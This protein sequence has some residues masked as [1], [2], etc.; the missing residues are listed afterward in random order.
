ASHLGMPLDYVLLGGL[1]CIFNR[2]NGFYF[3]CLYGFIASH[4]S[5]K[6]SRLVLICGPIVSVACGIWCGFL[7]DMVIEPF[8]LLLGKKGYV[9]KPSTATVAPPTSGDEK[10]AKAKGKNSKGDK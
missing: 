5:G 9:A 2:N 7:L 1:V 6:M 4:F 3:M 10:S 8:L